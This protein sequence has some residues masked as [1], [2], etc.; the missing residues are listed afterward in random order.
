MGQ[1]I[2][3]PAGRQGDKLLQRERLSRKELR[4]MLCI[5]LSFPEVNLLERRFE[6]DAGE[7][8]LGAGLSQIY[9]VTSVG[10]SQAGNGLLA[11]S[12]ATHTCKSQ[13]VVF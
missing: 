3:Y 10:L 12:P 8:P 5:A 6:E 4:C 1:S 2:I 9:G 7:S 13:L 11:L